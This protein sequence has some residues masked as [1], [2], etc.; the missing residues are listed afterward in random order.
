MSTFSATYGWLGLDITQR[1]LEHGVATPNGLSAANV[2]LPA[3]DHRVTLSIADTAGK[4]ASRTFRF[5]VAR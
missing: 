3:G 2:E 5:S 1:L 4:T